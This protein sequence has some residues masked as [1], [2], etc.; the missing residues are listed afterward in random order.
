MSP[1]LVDTGFIVALLDRSER[2]HQRCKDVLR[3]VSG[4]LVTCEAVIAE[5]CHLL[6]QQAGAAEA[7]LENV[8]KGDTKGDWVEYWSD[9]H[10]GI[11]VVVVQ[12]RKV[13]QVIP[14]SDTVDPKAETGLMK[15]RAAAGAIAAIDAANK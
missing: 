9:K 3:S 11:W 10:D 2:N 5:A 4:G 8:E 15:Q 7:I 1:T 14:P 13:T 12:N 6:R